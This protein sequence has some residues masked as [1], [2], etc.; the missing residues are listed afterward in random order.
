MNSSIQNKSTI[1]IT[2]AS[3]G[4]GKNLLIKALRTD[5]FCYAIVRD[6]NKFLE[7]M[8]PLS[9]QNLV[10]IEYDE[11]E[12]KLMEDSMYDS[13]NITLVLNAFDITP[14]KPIEKLCTEEIGKNTSFNI[15]TQCSLI[16][17]LVQS[18]KDNERKLRIIQ[19]DS[20]AAHKPIKGWSLYCA[21]KSYINMFIRVLHEEEDIPFV[22]YDPGVVDTKMQEEIRS[23]GAD[24]F[25][26]CDL[27]KSFYIEN[28]LNSP[29]A[30]AEDIFSRYIEKWE[31]NAQCAKF[32][33]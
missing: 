15:K 5:Y 29:I 13:T 26:D 28:K 25:P 32:G 14:I 11:I 31:S 24:N 9:H 27:F 19:M 22:L 2:G 8:N 18:C 20:G 1:V 7:E 10:V 3:S 30:V 21:A 12:D 23:A 4:I 16:I 33:E 6:K 17:K